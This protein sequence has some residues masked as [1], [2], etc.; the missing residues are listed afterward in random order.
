M[1]PSGEDVLARLAATIGDRYS[2]ERELGADGMA[3]VPSSSW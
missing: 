3:T 2:V 1:T